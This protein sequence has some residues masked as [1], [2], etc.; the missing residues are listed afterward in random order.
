[1]ISGYSPGC[2][3]PD[4][5]GTAE[6]TW[7]ALRT[8]DTSNPNLDIPPESCKDNKGDPDLGSPNE[9][10]PGG[11]PGKGAGGGPTATYP[12]CV[13]Q[14]MVLIVQESDKRCPDDCGSGGIMRFQFPY[15]DG[16][17]ITSITSLDV[18]E[19][20]NDKNPPQ[21]E[22]WDNDGNY[23]SQFFPTNAHDNS[24]VTVDLNGGAGLTNVREMFFRLDGSGSISTLEYRWC[25]PPTLEAAWV[26]MDFEDFNDDSS[27]EKWDMSGSKTELKSDGGIHD[28]GALRLRDTDSP[29]ISR[30][31][32]KQPYS[33]K[34]F[35][36]VKVSFFY[37]T[38]NTEDSGGAMDTMKIQWKEAATAAQLA[39]ANWQT[40]M[41]FPV[42]QEMLPFSV[43]IDVTDN[44]KFMSVRF[45]FESTSNSESI[46]IDD[47]KLEGRLA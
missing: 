6:V 39:S 11:G 46:Y 10:C 25:K 47:F 7:G 14:G 26:D 45:E 20:S 15:G 27:L 33:I 8:F 43:V 4:V 3:T 12:N 36:M 21:V 34:D 22:T 31:S 28:S 40:R 29:R 5:D 16:V 35:D 30:M 44:M 13:A 19:P 38:H 9:N 41:E 18:D 2:H 24:L 1:M 37:E 42:K 17:S 23:F 32:S